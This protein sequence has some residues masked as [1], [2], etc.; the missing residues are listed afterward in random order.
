MARN[1]GLADRIDILEVEQFVAT[2]VYEK[3][4]FAESNRNVTVT[5]LVEQYNKIIEGC[6]SDPSL[7]I[8]MGN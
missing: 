1:A 3:S 5:E 7:K 2:N 8:V 6:E 4:A